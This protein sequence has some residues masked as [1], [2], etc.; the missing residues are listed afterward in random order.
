MQKDIHVSFVIIKRTTCII[1]EKN[2]L[3]FY[4]A[5]KA[6]LPYSHNW[7]SSSL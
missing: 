3:G 5:D 4:Y 1:E 2:N 6:F 7:S